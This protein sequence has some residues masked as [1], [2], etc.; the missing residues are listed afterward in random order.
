MR[1]IAVTVDGVRSPGVEA[2]PPESSEAV[3]FVHGNPG[4]WRDFA[5]LVPQVGAFARV[6]AVD[7]PG[8]GRADKP[9][10]FDY[11]VDG[12]ARHLGAV[13]ADRGVERVHLVLHDF[14]GPW[15]LRWVAGAPR[16]V[17]SV[18][19]VNAGGMPG[20]R[21]HWAARVWRTPLLGELSM[22]TMS[23]AGFRLLFRQGAP[24]AVPLRQ[25]DRMY[26]DFDRGTARAVLRL[27]RST[28]P[29]A[30]TQFADALAPHDIPAVVI[31]GEADP[32]IPMRDAERFRE[33]FPSARFIRIR[34]SGHWPFLSTP[35]RVEAALLPWLRARTGA[36]GD[37]GGGAPR[38]GSASGPRRG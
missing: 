6:L 20:Y 28:P 16:T 32:Y 19:L 24:T 33:V 9:D 29:Q 13:L 1:E 31:W 14:G 17:A 25:V 2:G 22:A 38:A 36:G 23:R 26:D 15:A 5:E 35:A 11:T 21:W 8:Y 12:Y 30:G 34:D 3:V 4:S 7:M 37:D 10:D 27:Y 18:A